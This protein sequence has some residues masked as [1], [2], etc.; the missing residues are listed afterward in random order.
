MED[1]VIKY[2]KEGENTVEQNLEEIE[3]HFEKDKD[4]TKATEADIDGD[5]R[6]KS[7]HVKEHIAEMKDAYIEKM[8]REILDE[9]PELGETYNQTDIENKLKNKMQKES[10]TKKDLE[11]N[12]DEI[13][14]NIKQEAEEERLPSDDD[15]MG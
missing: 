10:L 12:I 6:T 5:E 15:R 2:E 8:A 13:T 3:R 9:N 1:A 11:N 14:E 4:C 7:E